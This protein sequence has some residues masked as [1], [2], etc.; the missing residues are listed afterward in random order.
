MEFE[1]KKSKTSF[2]L[3]DIPK[4]VFGN[5]ES[6]IGKEVLAIFK[7]KDKSFNTRAYLTITNTNKLSLRKYGSN[8]IS[9]YY[10]QEDSKQIYCEIKTGDFE[11]E[12]VEYYAALKTLIIKHRELGYGKS[13]RLSE[14]FTES[15]CRHRFQLYTITGKE[16]DAI[17]S[18]DK[19]VEIKSTY[20]NNGNTTISTS[21]KWDYL[22][23]MA[24]NIEENKVNVYKIE[25]KT[26]KSE[27][28]NNSKSRMSI[29]LSKYTE[30]QNPYRSFEFDVKN[31]KIIKL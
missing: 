28:E 31:K 15:L 4:E 25:Y 10:N 2:N 17:D 23:W 6:T 29:M 5:L 30:T 27:L 20:D 3:L 26:L 19:L 22:L 7:T 18:N 16:Y 24:F 21:A 9:E 12:F 13:T 1:V 11:K 8:S 14:G